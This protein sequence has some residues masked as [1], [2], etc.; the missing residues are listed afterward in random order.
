MDCFH[1]ELFSNIMFSKILMDFIKSNAIF[2]SA[3]NTYSNFSD[4]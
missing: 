2:T 4:K 3:L 1:T